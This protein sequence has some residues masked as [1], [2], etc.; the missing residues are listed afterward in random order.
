MGNGLYLAED[1]FD[2]SEIRVSLMG[3][4]RMTAIELQPKDECVIQYLHYDV[5]RG[6]IITK[7]SLKGDQ[8]VFRGY[9]DVR[10][11]YEAKFGPYTD[12]YTLIKR[13]K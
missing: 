4:M 7:T 13:A 2:G 6:R 9:L 12:D 5:S 10:K 1:V 8:S 11:R 3:K